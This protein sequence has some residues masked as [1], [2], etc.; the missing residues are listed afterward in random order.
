M[1]EKREGIGR[2]KNKQ[3]DEAWDARR[4]VAMMQADVE[5][6]RE[7]RVARLWSKKRVGN[8]ARGVRRR[9]GLSSLRTGVES[10][11]NSHQ[12]RRAQSAKLSAP[13]PSRPMSCQSRLQ[14]KTVGR[15]R[16]TGKLRKLE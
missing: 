16:R 1:E 5:Q 4:S 3:Q 13:P 10:F 7:N 8:C 12:P 11:G 6:T 15:Y 2:L 9:E 14:N